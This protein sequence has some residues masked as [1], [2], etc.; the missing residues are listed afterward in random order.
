MPKLYCTE[1][2]LEQGPRSELFDP[3]AFILGEIYVIETQISLMNA[4]VVNL[5]PT[6]TNAERLYETIFG[7]F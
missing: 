7:V 3:I 1:L 6:S 2:S 5:S 4:F